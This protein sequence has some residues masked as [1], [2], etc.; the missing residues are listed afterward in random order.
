MDRETI[1]RELKTIIDEHLQA[2][3][4]SLVDLTYRYEGKKLFLRIL[5]DRPE[6][7]ITVDEC[8]SANNEISRV[9]DERDILQERYILEVSSPGLDRPLR[10][11]SDFSRCVNKRIRVFLNESV[12]GK[13]ELEGVVSR[14]GEDR[15]YIKIEDE[16][17]EIPLA[18]ITKAKQTL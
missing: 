11:K 8:A 1:V 2:R 3:G 18:K 9:L 7:G 15:V 16:L 14:V 13:M 6:G 12:R 5:I 17:I 4:F 10:T